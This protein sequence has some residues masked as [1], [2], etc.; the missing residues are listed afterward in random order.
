MKVASLTTTGLSQTTVSSSMLET[1]ANA[2][3]LAQAVRVYLSRQRQGTAKTKTRAEVSRTKKKWY[4]QKHTGGARHGARTPNIF[5]GGG[6]SH[7]PTGTQ[8]WWMEL[9]KEMRRQ[10]LGVAI[11]AQVENIVIADLSLEAKSFR[12]ALNSLES[13]RILVIT[14]ESDLSVVR[15]IGNMAAVQVSSA[16]RVNVFDILNAWKVVLSEETLVSLEKRMSQVE[17]DTDKKSV[18]KTEKTTTKAAEKVKKSVSAAP[19]SKSVKKTT[20]KAAAAA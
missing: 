5:V 9:N 14:P 15:A 4:K 16:D 3:L 13:D 8:N 12:K 18:V 10:A 17:S 20:K 2:L 7:G 1:P 6:V 19:K 11:A